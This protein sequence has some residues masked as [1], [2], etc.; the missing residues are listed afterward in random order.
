MLHVRHG[1]RESGPV[2]HPE[3]AGY[4][5]VMTHQAYGP[6][7]AIPRLSR[8]L[9][10]L[11]VRVTFFIPGYSAERWPDVA[12]SIRD[13]GHEIAHHGYLHE[14]SRGATV[15]R[16]NDDCFADSKRSTRSLTSDRSATAPLWQMSYATPALLAKHGFRYNSGLMDSDYPYRLA[17]SARARI[18]DARRAD[19]ALVARRRTA[20]QLPA[21]S[22][23]VGGDHRPA[24]L[25]ETLAGHSSLMRFAD[26]G[27]LYCMPT[28]HPF[29][30]GRA[31]RA[32]A[33]ERLIRHAQD[34][35][36]IWVATGGEVAAHVEGLDLA[37][38]VNLPPVVPPGW[39]PP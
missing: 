23:R 21:G 15:S 32:A 10:R 9:D 28:V 3:T 5:D 34:I 20:V 12:R 8:I 37:P 17:V 27:G 16:R 30:S 4:L 11:A 13:A 25:L 7:T 18:A 2:D 29:I 26:V 33:L 22:Q 36:G 38:V 35:G 39:G 14:R 31:S 24:V 19:R 6:R 1:R